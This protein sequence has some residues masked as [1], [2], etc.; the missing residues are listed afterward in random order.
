M[1]GLS[2]VRSRFLLFLAFS[3]L[4][5]A[6][7]GVEAAH[8]KAIIRA[9]HDGA[10]E[11]SRNNGKHWK[12]AEVGAVLAAKSVVRTD[13]NATADI[14]MGHNGPTVRLMK[15]TTLSID[16]LDVNDLG[17][18]KVTDTQLDLRK[19]EIVGRVKKMAAASKYEIKF[20]G[21]VVGVR[22]TEYALSEKG[23]LR[24]VSGTAVL[25]YDHVDPQAIIQSGQK[26]F[27]TRSGLVEV[28]KLD[29][30]DEPIVN[31]VFSLT[32]ILRLDSCC[33]LIET[34]YTET[35]HRVERPV[36]P[37]DLLFPPA[38]FRRGF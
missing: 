17:V 31:E 19:G 30:D 2:N 12:K 9:I 20:P 6:P 28:Q 8:N 4:A 27:L 32:G 36:D 13:A 1:T 34:P 33:G 10:A 18:E 22:G 14:F 7:A 37:P 29:A 5:V 38:S 3:F 24:L 35:S 26:A 21:G 11:V 16:K 15:E 25:I 23:L